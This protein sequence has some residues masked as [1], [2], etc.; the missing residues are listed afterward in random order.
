M[1]RALRDAMMRA[2][3]EGVT[4]AARHAGVDAV[5]VR[6]RHDG[7][8]TLAVSDE[9]CGYDVAAARQGYGLD[10]ARTRLAAVGAVLDVQSRRG[11]GTCLT[12]TAP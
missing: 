7:R 12:V 11:H 1:D 6:L 8:V 10:E 5:H 2:A 3:R 9:G 4:N